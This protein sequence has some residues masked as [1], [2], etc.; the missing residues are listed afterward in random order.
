MTPMTEEEFQEADS[1]NIWAALE[2][3]HA[4]GVTVETDEQ[5]M[6]F[7]GLFE[8]LMQGIIERDWS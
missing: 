4:M 1:E 2:T 5:R 7:W 8:G 6:C 3:A